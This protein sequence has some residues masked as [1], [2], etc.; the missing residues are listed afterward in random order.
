MRGFSF[1]NFDEK[2]EQKL[3]QDFKSLAIAKLGI[4]GVLFLINSLLGLWVGTAGLMVGGLAGGVHLSG[5]VLRSNFRRVNST[6]FRVKAFRQVRTPNRARAY[7]R[8]TSRT[9]GGKS[10]GSSGDDGGDSGGDPPSSNT[11]PFLVTPFQNFYRKLNS[12]LLPWRV[13]CCLGC[14]CLPCHNRSVVE[15]SA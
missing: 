5:T 8:G 4:A 2:R 9:A 12:V 3:V 11:Y 1:S 13:W 6:G 10:G 15:V 7:R 14:W